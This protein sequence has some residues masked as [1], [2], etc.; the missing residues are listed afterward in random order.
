MPSQKPIR[1]IRAK[2]PF[3]DWLK[4]LWQRRET[5]WFFVWKDLKV[6]YQQPIFG[7]LWS[8]FQPLIYFAVIL[9]VIRFSGRTTTE[10]QMPFE[11]YLLC[12]LAIWNFTTSVILGGMSSMQSNAGLVTKASFP[13]LY[14]ILS[15]LIKSLFDLAIVLVIVLVAAISMKVQIPLLFPVHLLLSVLLILP[16]SFGFACI[17][18]TLIVWNRHF[19]HAIPILLYATIFVLPI[20][21]SMDKIENQW[22]RFFYHFNPI[23]GAME[24][25]RN[26][27][28]P[29]IWN[30]NPMLLWS[31]SSIVVLI[32]GTFFFRRMEQTLADEL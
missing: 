18:A 13:R 30:L 5:L 12:G 32:I 4:R 11:L 9:S 19:R 7:L 15:P 27:F 8:V 20:F 2:Q 25:L 24:V 26:G 1:V 31:I 17:S 23:A 3:S 14:L 16:V 29:F 22:L 21:Y 28:N 6:Q 10:T